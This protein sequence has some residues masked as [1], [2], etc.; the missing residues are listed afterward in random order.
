MAPFV[1]NPYNYDTRQASIRSGL[2]CTQPSM[3]KQEFKEECDINT[4]VR[5]FGL[6]GEVPVGLKAPEYAEYES[7]MDYQ[8]AIQA[9]MEAEER[10]MEMPA[11][12][13]REFDND[14]QR[15]LEFCTDKQNLP[16]LKEWGLA[17]PDL[18]APAPVLVKLVPEPPVGA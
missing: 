6:T 10:F 13:R 14:P 17:H 12:V 9:V 4:I 8:T 16:R 18:P 11:H 1:R 5:N 3:A 15:F 2:A 7:V